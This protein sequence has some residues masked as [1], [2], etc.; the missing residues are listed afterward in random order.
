MIEPKFSFKYGNIDFSKLNFRI[1][2]DNNKLIYSLEDG[3]EITLKQNKY[4]DYDASEWVVYYS[5]KGKGKSKNLSEIYDGDFKI[6]LPEHKHAFMGDRFIEGEPKIVSMKGCV[7][8]GKYRTDDEESATE[9]SFHEHYIW[10][11]R[12]KL[13]FSNLNGVPSN[14]MMP[15]FEINQGDKGAIVA[16]GWTGCWR[17]EFTKRNDGIEVKTGL[18]SA[19][20]Y[21]NEGETIRTSS[22]LVMEYSGKREDAFNKFRRLIKNNFSCRTRRGRKKNYL[23]ANELWGGITS[24]EMIKRINEYKKYGIVFEQEW[25]DAGWYGGSKKCDDA[26]EGDWS[27]FTGDWYMNPRIHTK[28]MVDVKDA[29]EN[30][31]MRMMLWIEPERIIE[32][33][34]TSKA[35]PEYLLRANEDNGEVSIHCL[36]DLGNEDALNCVF[37]TVCSFMDSLNVECLRQDF[38]FEPEKY[39]RVNEEEGRLGIREIKHV[40]GLYKFWD[41]LL[42]KYPDL[43]IDN[44]AS[45]GR[46]IDIETLKRAI[47]FFRSD[48]QCEFNPNPDVTQTHGTNISRYLP[49]TGCTSKVKNDTYAVRSTY[50]SSWGGAFYNTIF[51]TMDENDFI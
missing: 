8:G 22:V 21:L 30:A 41:M 45:G 33:T 43:L 28:K 27:F 34:E 35:H 7:P 14:G 26:F 46:R 19:E 3:L 40:M 23:L 48:Y 10:N 36:M 37:E 42:E 16:I 44:C 11:D 50:S 5:Y 1:V 47:P 32:G 9:F 18:K 6:N 4:E 39:W 49:Y 51:Q 13:E 2:E 29:C 25:I 31:G 38:N 20:F 17:A 12:Q 15:F 24:E